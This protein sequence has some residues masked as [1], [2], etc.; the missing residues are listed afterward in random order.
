[1]IGKP[2]KGYTATIDSLIRTKGASLAE[3]YRILQ[4][5]CCQYHH[6]LS[7]EESDDGDDENESIGDDESEIEV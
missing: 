7:M 3:K 2:H 4:K 6:L 1:M 5:R